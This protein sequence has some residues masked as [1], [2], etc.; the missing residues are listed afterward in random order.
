MKLNYD[1]L[2]KKKKNKPKILKL[3]TYHKVSKSKSWPQVIKSHAQVSE[4]RNYGQGDCYLGS[5]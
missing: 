5:G 4:C 2:I 1:L 3:F